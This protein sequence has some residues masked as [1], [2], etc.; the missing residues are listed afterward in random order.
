MGRQGEIEKLL[1]VGEPSAEGFPVLLTGLDECGEASQ[2]DAADG[3]LGI[4][5]LQIIPHVAVDVFV[6]V[7]FGKL[8][9]L[10]A[11]PLVAGVVLAAGAPAVAS[12]V[13]EALDERFE[14]HVARDVHRP[15]FTHRHL[16]CGV[17]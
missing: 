15:S 13:A 6:V 4:E 12:P 11:E 5:G 1:Q 3:G 8:T 7:S 10:P 2:L 9:E 17:E 14:L 16:V